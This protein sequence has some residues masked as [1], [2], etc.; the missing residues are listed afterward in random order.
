MFSSTGGFR[1]G[2]PGLQRWQSLSH[3]APERAKRPCPP[4]GTELGS[5]RGQSSLRQAETVQWFEDAHKRLDAKLDRLRTRDLQMDYNTTGAQM[6]DAKK[7]VRSLQKKV[8][9]IY[10]V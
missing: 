9:Q 6:F 3:L 1:Q 7:K 5:S 2:D 8:K 10:D 4:L